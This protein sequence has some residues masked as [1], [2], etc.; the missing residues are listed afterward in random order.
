MHAYAHGSGD[1]DEEQEI[2]ISVY[3]DACRINYAQHS[4]Y[5]CFISEK[6]HL[7]KSPPAARSRKCDKLDLLRCPTACTTTPAATHTIQRPPPVVHHPSFNV[8]SHTALVVEFQRERELL[9][10]CML[11][12]LD[13]T[14][15]VQQMRFYLST[16][17]YA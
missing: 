9:A 8:Q 11:V 14:W 13:Q 10:S 3:L 4:R 16:Y 5:G 7:I 2:I 1:D 12:F 17:M 6:Y 15:D